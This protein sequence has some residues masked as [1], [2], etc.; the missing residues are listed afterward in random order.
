M[1]SRAAGNRAKR[2]IM[3]G[4]RLRA[5][6]CVPRGVQA[7]GSGPARYAAGAQCAWRPDA[8]GSLQSAAASLLL[9][10]RRTFLESLALGMLAPAW[11]HRAT[12]KRTSMYL[13]Y[14]SFAV[15]M[16]QGRD[17][18]DSTAAA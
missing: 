13:A 11:M 3:I 17:I 9:Q 12:R 6:D 1:G 2:P 15:R 18:L 5:A 4:C 16:L 7:H 14:T 10:D 8:A